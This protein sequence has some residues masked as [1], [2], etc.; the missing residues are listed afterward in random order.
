MQTEGTARERILNRIRAGLNAPTLNQAVISHPVSSW[1]A[2][3]ADALARFQTECAANNTECILT[4]NSQATANVVVQVLGS[5]PPGEIYVQHA[6]ELRAMATMWQD[7]RPLRWL[8][9]TGP[10]EDAQAVITLAEALIAET[11]SV[12]VSSSC[13][14]RGA[15]VVAPIHIVIAWTDQLVSELEAA[16]ARLRQ[17]RSIAEISFACLISGSSR[18]ADIEK[19]LVM[20]A[21]GPRRLVVVVEQRP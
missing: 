8:S 14:G 17:R 13:G 11:G 1:F 7:G 16:L 21:H 12:L 15:S 10:A 5:V 9:E 4:E 2:P 18:T 19:T 6:P 20:G 3:V